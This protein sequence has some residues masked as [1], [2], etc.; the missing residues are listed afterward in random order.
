MPV[1]VWFL[2]SRAF[3]FVATLGASWIRLARRL[4]VTDAE[5]LLK[6]DSRRPIVYLRSFTE[7]AASYTEQSGI[8]GRTFEESLA[9]LLSRYGPFI[10]IAD[11]RHRSRPV[12]AALLEAKGDWKAVARQLTN[13]A[14]IVIL[15]PGSSPGLQWELSLIA[16]VVPRD[17][18]LFLVESHISR[19]GDKDLEYTDFRA[20]IVQQLGCELPREING[21]AFLYLDGERVRQIMRPRLPWYRRFFGYLPRDVR[22][23]LRPFLERANLPGAFRLRDLQLFEVIPPIAGALIVAAAVVLWFGASVE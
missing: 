13:K 6:V 9:E 5:T 23:A 17:R 16:D 8:G 7:D 1:F 19:G 12:G 11:P 15:R 20:N 10:A 14:A 18:I 2:G 21:V 22:R 4:R 3:P